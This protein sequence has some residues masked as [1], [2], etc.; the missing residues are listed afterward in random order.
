MGWSLQFFRSLPESEQTDWIAYTY[1][2]RLKLLDMLAAMDELRKDKKPVDG[3]AFS[4]VW[5]KLLET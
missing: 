1:H 2:Q 4:A 3:A 5:L